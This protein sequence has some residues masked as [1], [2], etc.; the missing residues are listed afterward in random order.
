LIHPTAPARLSRLALVAAVLGV[1]V[2]GCTNMN[3]ARR[4]GDLPA[5]VNSPAAQAI[6]DAD[7]HPGRYPTFQEIPPVPQDVRPAQA[8]RSAV[9]SIKADNAALQAQVAADPPTLD[10][11]E[12]WA[13]RKAAEATP[14][15]PPEGPSTEDYA[16][17][18]RDRAKPP[19]KPK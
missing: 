6:L 8:W 13:A 10:D 14:P 18:L 11:S 17:A 15:P 5:P 4:L 9:A 1:G 19:P 12:G 2:S 7:R 3:Q 16:R